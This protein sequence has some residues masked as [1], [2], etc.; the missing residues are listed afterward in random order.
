LIKK[1][2]IEDLTE[3]LLVACVKQ[4]VVHHASLA[5]A[6]EEAEVPVQ[7]QQEA[8]VQGVDQDAQ[9]KSHRQLVSVDGGHILAT[10]YYALHVVIVPV[11]LLFPVRS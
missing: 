1:N 6:K 2:Q 3:S 10:S 8:H 11:F 4:P 5:Q 7:P 9:C